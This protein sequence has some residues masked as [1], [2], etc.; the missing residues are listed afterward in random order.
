MANQVKIM[1]IPSAIKIIRLL[2]TSLPFI[3]ITIPN[4]SLNDAIALLSP[5]IISLAACCVNGSLINE[6][7]CENGRLFITFATTAGSAPIGTYT[8]AT[9]PAALPMMTLNEEK[10]D[11]VLIKVATKLESAEKVTHER[12]R[13]TQTT[14]K[15]SAPIQLPPVATIYI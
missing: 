11:S 12:I 2:D 10:A 13:Y 5:R 4:D 14:A 9:N 8:P 6:A 7:I 3:S 1:V 15:F